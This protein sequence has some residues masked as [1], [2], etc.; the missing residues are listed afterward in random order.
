MMGFV[1]SFHCA[2]MCG[3]IALAVPLN[4]KTWRNKISGSIVYNFGRTVTYTLMGLLFGL[5]GQGLKL[6]GFQQTV[7]VIMGAIMVLSV[8]FP[9]LFKNKL[10]L[11][12]FLNTI[13]GGIKNKLGLLFTIK[14]YGSLFLIGILNGLL[15]CG[16]VYMALASAVA[17]TDVFLGG[18]FMLAFGLAT[19]PML[20]VINLI[21][22]TAG[23]TL[24]RKMNKLIPYVVVVVG[25]LFILRGLDLKI[26]FLSPP[27]DK[28]ELH[29]KQVTDTTK[30]PKKACCH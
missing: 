26:P 20:L 25:I 14:S 2:G 30:T 17:T 8:V 16:L 5:L 10:N 4:N 15:P 11:P 3:P 21:G 6:G 13:V 19:M 28:L 29:E 22:N 24:F 23:S 18:L 9:A 27:A 1:G 12:G 7:A